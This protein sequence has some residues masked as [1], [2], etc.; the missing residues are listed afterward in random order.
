MLGALGLRDTLSKVTRNRNNLNVHQW[1]NGFQE[2]MWYIHT[3][4]C[5]SAM[6]KEDVLPFAKTGMDFEHIMLN[7]ISQRKILYGLTYTWNLKKS[8]IKKEPLPGVGG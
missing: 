5:Y 3:M 8:N 2:K 6:Q 4:D 7:E 1:M